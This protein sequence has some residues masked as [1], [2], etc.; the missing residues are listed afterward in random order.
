MDLQ[1]GVDGPADTKVG[2]G[3]GVGSAQVRAL[4]TL[5]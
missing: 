2:H 3:R 1:H 4:R 5:T